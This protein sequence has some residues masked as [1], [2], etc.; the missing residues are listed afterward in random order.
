MTKSVVVIGAGIS[1]IQVAQQLS[2][3]GIKVHLI[4]S[5][6][7]VGGLATYLGRVFPTDDCALCL[8]A[9]TD[10]FDGKHRRCEYRSLLTQKSDLELYTQTEIKSISNDEKGF[11][12]SIAI[13]PRHVL[14]DKCVV[15]LECINVCEV[16]VEDEY[17]IHGG[18][19]KAIY[20][21]IP[22]G[23]PLAP[24]IDIENC[25][26]CGKCI[27]V[28]GVDAIDLDEKVKNKTIKADAI[29][30]AT[31]V[32]ERDPS[33]LPGYNYVNSDDILTQKELARLIDPAGST[34][35]EVINAAGEKVN[36]VTMIMCA[37]SRDLNAKEY[38]S[39]ACCTYSLKHAI[40][41]RQKG[42]DVTACF[43]DLRIPYSSR[44]YLIKAQE[45]GVKFVRGKPDRILLRDGKP[46]V[47]LE[48]TQSQSIV[49]I[50]SDIVA[51][52]SSL[53]P[54]G[55]KDEI[56]AGY[57]GQ[58]GFNEKQ[59]KSSKIY[60]CGTATGPADIPTCIAEA[61]SVALQVYVDLQGGN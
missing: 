42:I 8:D 46:I 54:H 50:E 18:K 60:A 32:D 57:S 55:A 33:G 47:Y 5:K 53:E 40:L 11:S 48:N 19:R 37:G 61:N 35:G 14:L 49:E 43:M 12:V 10:M 9:C 36:N 31:G 1:G 41:L 29:I 44:H 4:E 15:C 30:L 7:I 38:C 59:V 58:H 3:L 27:E 16:E 17:G 23:V 24:L 22:Q 45:A 2:D 34:N 25:T 28:C 6:P 20:R 13:Q 39:Q 26:K 21:P 52:A 51:L 56:L